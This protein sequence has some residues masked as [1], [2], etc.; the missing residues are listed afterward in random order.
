[1]F[2][3]RL[4]TVVALLSILLVSGSGCHHTSADSGVSVRRLNLTVISRE[5]SRFPNFTSED[6]NACYDGEI[7]YHHLDSVAVM[8]G[9]KSV[10]LP[11]AISGGLVT[12]EELIAWAVEDSRNGFCQE[13]VDSKH[14]L[15]LFSY[16]YPEF[17][18]EYINDVYET[19][20][21]K[22]HLI[23]DF[24]II[25]PGITI[26][27]RVFLVDGGEP[28]E[29]ID[30]ED[31][32]VQV[33]IKEVNPDFITLSITQSGGQQFG[34][35]FINDHMIFFLEENRFLGDTTPLDMEPFPL[36][37]GGTTEF[38]LHWEEDYERLSPGTY[39]FKFYVRDFYDPAD[40][41]PLCQN[42]ADQQSYILHFTVE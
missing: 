27:D 42:F 10:D 19:P 16:T 25:R 11:E 36:N 8:I 35:L 29:R 28:N 4:V 12:V 3:K 1:M 22:T 20:D 6:L 14:G 33:E 40:I 7:T 18:L 21:G 9:D 17:R 2:Y 41:H 34:D 31:W 30:R 38:T 26:T 32:G 39:T 15:C 24:D 13:S 5:E 23:R 37:M